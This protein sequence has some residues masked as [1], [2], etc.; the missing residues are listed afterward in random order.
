[1][2]NTPPLTIVMNA[3][4]IN[5]PAPTI[6]SIFHIRNVPNHNQNPIT[7]AN[8]AIHIHN[9]N[10]NAFAI[11]FFSPLIPVSDTITVLLSPIY[12]EIFS[13]VLLS[14]KSIF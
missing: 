1:M 6:A 13:P 3:G 14:V 9:K 8:P 12:T 4:H 2:N 5:N 11:Y 10:K 7:A